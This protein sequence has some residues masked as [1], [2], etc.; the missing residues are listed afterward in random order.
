M[1]FKFQKVN[2]TALPQFPL[3]CRRNKCISIQVILALKQTLI[4]HE[5]V[6]RGEQNLP[7]STEQLIYHYNCGDLKDV[8]LSQEASSIANL[9]NISE[10][11]SF[12]KEQ[13]RNF[14]EYM[15]EEL[16]F[17]RNRKM[18]KRIAKIVKQEPKR[19]MLFAVGAGQLFQ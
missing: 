16:F 3:V 18:A 1:I 13:A 12:Q 19:S 17:K 14:E 8:L 6:R 11:S 7:F 2:G 9:E 10:T 15:K 5:K 4:L